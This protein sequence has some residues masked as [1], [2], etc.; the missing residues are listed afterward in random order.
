M[1]NPFKSWY[2]MDYYQNEI[3]VLWDNFKGLWNLWLQE[4]P[5]FCSAKVQ[6][7]LIF[8]W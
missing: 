6:R 5:L 3:A 1:R 2:G 8:L 4:F 7:L